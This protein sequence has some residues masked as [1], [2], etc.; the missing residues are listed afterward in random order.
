MTEHGQKGGFFRPMKHLAFLSAQTAKKS[1]GALSQGGGF[2]RR[3]QAEFK[4]G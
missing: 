2:F 3:I 4:A 1:G